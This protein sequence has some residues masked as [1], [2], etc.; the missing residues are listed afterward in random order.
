MSIYFNMAKSKNR[1]KKQSR[2]NG[3]EVVVMKVPRKIKEPIYRI[4]RCVSVTGLINQSSG[5]TI[6]ASTAFDC[7]F[8]TSLSAVENYVA[9]A[10]ASSTAV[11]G[12]SDFSNLFDQFTIERVDV[13]I[14]FTNNTSSTASA[15]VGMPLIWYVPD[16]NSYDSTALTAIQQYPLVN[17]QFMG[18][19]GGGILKTS[20]RPRILRSVVNAAGTATGT[21][22]GQYGDQW[23]PTS[24][25]N[26]QFLALKIVYDPMGTSTNTNTGFIEV[27]H[28]IHFAFK[29]PK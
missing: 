11:P 29:D 25:G 3:S 19:H 16:Y 5:I 17:R 2:S 26:V 23:I 8:V 21:N 6:N 14:F 24:N 12:T 4:N 27:V 9:G 22:A 28:K 18:E 20:Y 10:L 15:T 1:S 7:Q 13:E